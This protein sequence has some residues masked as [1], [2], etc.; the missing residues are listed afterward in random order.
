[1]KDYKKEV[2]KLIENK[3]KEKNDEYDRLCKYGASTSSTLAEI[4]LLIEL[5][6]EFKKL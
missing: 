1:M 4:D 6:E 5:K 2:I 3:I